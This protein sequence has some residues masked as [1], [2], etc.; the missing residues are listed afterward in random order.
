MPETKKSASN[1]PIYI[2][3]LFIFLLIGGIGYLVYK[4][5]QASK[6][7]QK[8][9]VVQKTTTYVANP[10]G[11][12][13]TLKSADGPVSLSDFK[14]KVVLMFFGFT[15]C[16]NACPVGM[17]EM[18]NA[19][20]LLSEDEL[21]N[22]Q[23]LFISIDPERDK[24]PA[25]KEYGHYFHPNILGITGT[26]EEVAKVAA[27]FGVMYSKE[28]LVNSELGYGFSH[29]STIYLV[30]PQGIFS[31]SFVYGTAPEIIADEVKYLLKKKE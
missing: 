24:L 10:Q 22:V 25:L 1:A 11:G 29:T 7:P 31:D 30:N 4:N 28:K 14:G 20:S 15:T 18:T 3:L 27:K 6:P 16:T 2:I 26:K 5:S 21:K 9:K 13:F 23:G 8:D 17:M 19:F 12:D